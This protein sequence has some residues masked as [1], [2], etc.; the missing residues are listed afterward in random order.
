MRGAF[1]GVGV[2]PF[3][4]FEALLLQC[5]PSSQCQPG[6]STKQNADEAKC[7]Q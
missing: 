4:K 2:V 6:E 5:S 1:S 3:D 7:N